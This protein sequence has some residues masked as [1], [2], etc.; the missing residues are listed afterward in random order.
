MS[1]IVLI[2]RIGFNHIAPPKEC[3][4]RVRDSDSK[5]FCDICGDGIAYGEQYIEDDAEQY[6]VACVDWEE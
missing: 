1:A 3:Q 5:G 6:C 2:V 4:L